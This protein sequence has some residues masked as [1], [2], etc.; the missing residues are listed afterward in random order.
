MN[1]RWI[2][3][4]ALPWRG[5]LLLCTLLMLLETGAALAVPWLAGRFAGRLLEGMAQGGSALLL[6]LLTLLALQAA[7]SFVSKLLLGNAAE[8]ILADLRV[9]LYDHLQAL[10]LSWFQQRRHGD[11]LS[12]LTNDVT[13]LASYLSGTLLSL[14]P[15]LLTVA[16]AL[17]LMAGID[18]R[19]T[20]L[21]LLMM[22]LFFVVMKVMGRRLRPL[23]GQL[24]QAHADS[25]AV[26]EENLAMLPAIKT[27]TRE[28][29]ESARYSDQVGQV[30][31]L[32]NTERRIYTALGPTVQFLGAAG[33]VLM[34]WLLGTAQEPRSP[35]EL[36]SFLLYAA[37]LTR[38]IGSLADVYGQTRQARGALQRLGDVLREPTEPLPNIG[39]EL[40]PVQGEIELQGLHFSYPGRTP[41]LQGLDL[42]I[43]AGETVAL[44]G[45]NGAGKSTLAHLLM[46]LMEPTQGRIC[47]DG[48][49]IAGVTLPSLRR[50]IGVVPQHV[51]LFNGSVFDNI[52][53]GLPGATPEAVQAAARAAQAHGFISALPNGYDTVVGDHGVRLS[54][55]QRQRIALARALLKDPPIL[56]LDEAT[57]MFDP[58]AERSFIADCHDT[59]RRRTVI[60]IT[61]RPASLALAD[62]VLRLEGGQIA[63]LH[64]QPGAEPHIPL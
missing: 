55:G 54:G 17:V 60:L 61:H 34:L 48:H 51:L 28:P 59:L 4:F 41:A 1:L 50:Q 44:T 12:L 22:P 39:H 29:L 40:P 10:P 42:R 46:R 31:R 33:M 47:I 43:S 23:S 37:V 27:F 45:P 15:M 18:A 25:V 63:A 5:T 11:V 20:L 2:L 3:S 26:A 57:A 14:L 49:D 21:V 19:M 8:A 35:A 13:Q 53:Y 6:M 16:G 38:P 52:A 7:L 58:E 24:Q 32:S 56:I 30:V 64:P 9:R 62:R 36:V